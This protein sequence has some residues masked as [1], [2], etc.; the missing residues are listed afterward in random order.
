MEQSNLLLTNA[1]E[2]LDVREEELVN[3]EEKL[4]KANGQL[5]HLNTG[6]RDAH[7]LIRGLEMSSSV[8]YHPGI[9]VGGPAYDESE[10]V[11][12]KWV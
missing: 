1:N 6:L 4:M 9:R 2:R 5:E 7:R 12:R 11:R 10:M 3:L 8:R